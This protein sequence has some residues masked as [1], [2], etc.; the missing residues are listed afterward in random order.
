MRPA[1]SQIQPQYSMCCSMKLRYPQLEPGVLPSVSTVKY[2][3]QLFPDAY[4]VAF[5]EL[6]PVTLS[7]V[8]LLCLIVPFWSRNRC[9]VT[10][11]AWGSCVTKHEWVCWEGLKVHPA[12]RGSIFQLPAKTFLKCRRSTQKLRHIPEFLWSSP[13]MRKL[14]N[15]A[16]LKLWMRR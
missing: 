1:L 11:H 9:R 5:S 8:T 6:K 12:L 2:F 15:V 3:P 13:S 10:A 14:K 16:K 4:M 7:L